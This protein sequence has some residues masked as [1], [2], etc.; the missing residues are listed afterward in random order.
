MEI[1]KQ[2]V[3]AFSLVLFI[4]MI[5]VIL[6]GCTPGDA[7]CSLAEGNGRSSQTTSGDDPSSAI[8]GENYAEYTDDTDD[9]IDV[10]SSDYG[11]L[12]DIGSNTVIASKD[13]EKRIYPASMTKVMTM[14]VAYENIEDLTEEY[15]FKQDVYDQLYLDGASIAGF[16]P[17]E[18]VPLNDIMY[19]AALA[20]G[21]DCTY[22]LA[23]VVAGSE[24]KFADLMNEK[25]R[26]LGLT[27]TH[28]TN[29]SGLH[30]N[31][32]YSTCHD[33][34]VMMKYACSI[35]Y[36][37]TMFGTYEYTSTRT[38]E[39]PEGIVL[40]GTMYSRMVGDEAEE[41]YIQ[42]GKTGYTNEARYCLVSF[43]AKCTEKESPE[44]AP[45]YV[46]V[47][48]HATGQYTPIFDHIKAYAKYCGNGKHSLVGV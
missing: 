6:S 7:D 13:A 27:G 37:K 17:G 28:F 29:V 1:K 46:M 20:S 23:D 26:E 21:A 43:A 3:R 47:T 30:D 10:I 32:H 12:I 9:D 24:E 25:V 35:P 38:E 44:T 34:A 19:G 14:I 48:A 15:T 33:I 8:C 40:Y 5:L 45:Q 4:C 22:A 11:I 41:I 42:G 31:D 39:H 16:L 36:L 18:T 2:A